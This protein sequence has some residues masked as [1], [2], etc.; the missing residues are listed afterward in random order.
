MQVA[1]WLEH[2]PSEDVPPES[3]WHH[4]EMLKAHFEDMK[5]RWKDPNSKERYES[6]PDEGTTVKFD[7]SDVRSQLLAP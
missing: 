5:R 3:I 4:D 7:N 6:V 2:L 1:S